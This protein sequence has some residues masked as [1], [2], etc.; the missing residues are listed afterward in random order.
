MT[1]STVRASDIAQVVKFVWSG[2]TGSW[3]SLT[4]IKTSFP[5]TSVSTPIICEDDPHGKLRIQ[6]TQLRRTGAKKRRSAL[7][8]G[9]EKEGM[10]IFQRFTKI[11]RHQDVTK[12]RPDFRASAASSH[13]RSSDVSHT[14]A[15]PL[16][17]PAY[18]PRLGR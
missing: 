14:M 10:S 3:H 18:P 12:P 17:P 8:K 4:S 9:R 7:T 6:R 1:E 11:K 2:N 13:P 5:M 16:T 15:L